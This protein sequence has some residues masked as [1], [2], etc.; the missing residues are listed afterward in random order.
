MALCHTQPGT[1]P[2]NASGGVLE[3]QPL[4]C[5]RSLARLLVPTLG[6]KRVCCWLGMHQ[7]TNATGRIS[8]RTA[9]GSVAGSPRLSLSCFP[10]DFGA[11]P[12]TMRIPRHPAT[13]STLIRPGFPRASGHPFHGHSAGQS[14]RSDAGLALLVRGARRGQFLRP[15]AHRFALE[16]DPVGVVHQAVKDGIG[17]GRIADQFV[18]VVHRHLA[19]HD[20]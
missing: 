13:Q 18:P 1:R 2:R 6:L 7:V 12:V 8:A 11:R 19:G 16:I 14:E 20:G 3:A 15:P 4:V 10:L 9:Q 17:Q 5:E